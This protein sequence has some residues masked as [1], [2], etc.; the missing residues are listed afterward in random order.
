MVKKNEIDKII[1]KRSLY[2]QSL[3]GKTQQ[4]DKLKSTSVFLSHTPLIKE[5]LKYFVS[6]K[7]ATRIAQD[8]ESIDKIKNKSV[9]FSK[10]LNNISQEDRENIVNLF[11]QKDEWS[12]L[13]I[14]N[15]P[16]QVETFAATLRLRAS[17][18]KQD[19]SIQSDEAYFNFKLY[20]LKN[21]FR[22]LKEPQLL[23]EDTTVTAFVNSEE[24]NNLMRVAGQF[25][26]T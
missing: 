18:H 16:Q 10:S 9:A 5:I 6:S 8:L 20:L 26:S 3:D 2:L 23:W 12:Y 13:S 24:D 15:L 11:L 4:K 22:L 7:Q 14:K 19:V 17:I 25:T 21:W 1:T